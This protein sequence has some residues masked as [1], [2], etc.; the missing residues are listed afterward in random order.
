MNLVQAL[1]EQIHLCKELNRY[2]CGIFVKSPE[3]GRIVMQCIANLSYVL[4]DIQVSKYQ[5]Y[6]DICWNNGSMIQ[7]WCANDFIPI[8]GL[9]F[10]GVIIESE[11]DRKIINES[12]LRYVQPILNCDG[13]GV[14]N[15]DNIKQ[16]IHIVEI[17]SNDIKDFDK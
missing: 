5:H 17:K 2:R 12:I 8:R 16:R 4:N 15:N 7:V 3:Q 13:L 11:I 14:D 6:V 10:N 1:K 9:R